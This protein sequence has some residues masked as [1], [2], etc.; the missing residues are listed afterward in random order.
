MT[1][2]DPTGGCAILPTFRQRECGL[3]QLA[4]GA[5]HPTGS[6]TKP[7]FTYSWPSL[8]EGAGLGVPSSRKACVGFKSQPV[9]TYAQGSETSGKE[10]R[11]AAHP[12]P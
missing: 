1:A 7:P 5:S 4:R 8:V 10:V 2:T 3:S 6:E 9:A 11:P 12:L